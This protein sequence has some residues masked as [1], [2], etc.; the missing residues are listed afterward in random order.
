MRSREFW[1]SKISEMLIGRCIWE[2]VTSYWTKEKLPGSIA[3]GGTLEIHQSTFLHFI[4]KLPTIDELKSVGPGINKISY[5]QNKTNQYK[6]I[7]ICQFLTR[8]CYLKLFLMFHKNEKLKWIDYFYFRF[9]ETNCSQTN[10]LFRIIYISLC[11]N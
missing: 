6:I 9:K 3:T 8:P 1:D 5:L 7:T 11:I 10:T 2:S 4:L